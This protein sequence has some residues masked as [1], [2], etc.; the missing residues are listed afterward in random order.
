MLFIA[1]SL[2]MMDEISHLCGMRKIT[3][4]FI[5]DPEGHLAERHTLIMDNNVVVDLIDEVLPDAEFFD[6]II[7]PGFINAHCHLELSHMVD[8]IKRGTSLHGFINEI[9]ATRKTYTRGIAE[10]IKMADEK[11]WVNGIQGVGDICNTDDTFVVKAHSRIRYHSFIEL[12]NFN[13]AFA[14]DAVNSGLQLQKKLQDLRLSSSLVPHAPYSVPKELFC[15]IKIQH[16]QS[17]SQWSIHS[18][19]TASENE[20]FLNGSGQM[21][22]M[23]KAMDINFDWFKPTGMNSLESTADY[24]PH[25]SNLLF[26]HNTFMQ[27]NDVAGLKS[28]GL[29]DQSWFCLCVKANLYIENQLP[30]IPMLERHQCKIVIGTDSL[31]SNDE[32]SILSELKTIHQTFPEIE[33]SKLLS[34]ATI[35]G[36]EYFD[37]RTL[38]TF[39][40]GNKP[41][42]ILIT[43]S[44]NKTI[45]ELASVRRMI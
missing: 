15:L 31:A 36:A 33:I 12:F 7:S 22:E 18:Q 26:V 43:E 39:R 10:S 21:I 45:G 42:V 41:G 14:E 27:E 8:K 11:M 1:G 29:M 19:E 24:F 37:W 44:T 4:S 5:L 30:D 16:D 38:G 23:F 9:I 6:G 34:W 20:M 25:Q 3:A 2:F 13:P 17:P 40:K 35:N 32:L 28:K